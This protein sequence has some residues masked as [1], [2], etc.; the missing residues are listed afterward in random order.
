MN[1]LMATFAAEDQRKSATG[2]MSTWKCTTPGLFRPAARVTVS[3]PAQR[4]AS[5]FG[6]HTGMTAYV[7]HSRGASDAF[8]TKLHEK[9][10]HESVVGM[11]SPARSTFNVI[12]I[13]A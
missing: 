13:K 1:D 5:A 4:S 11:F 10:T 2:A 3:I 7:H 8:S 12:D 6:F 9:G